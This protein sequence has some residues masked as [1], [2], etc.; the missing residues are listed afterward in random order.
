MNTGTVIEIQV[1]VLIFIPLS[2]YIAIFITVLFCIALALHFIQ[3]LERSIII[4]S[5]AVPE[6]KINFIS[7]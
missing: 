3:M 1:H 2:S 4:I 6:I 5:N 7:L